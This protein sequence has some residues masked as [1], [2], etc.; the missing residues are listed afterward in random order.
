MTLVVEI[1]KASRVHTEQT[2]L[3]LCRFTQTLLEAEQYY[4]WLKQIGA[5]KRNILHY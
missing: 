1:F 3:K 2:C 5:T 4:T